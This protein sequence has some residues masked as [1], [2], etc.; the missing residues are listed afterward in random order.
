LA[1]GS[2]AEFRE[3]TPQEWARREELAGTEGR[4]YRSVGRIVAENAE[5]IDR[6]FPR[7]MR[8]V[9][10]YNLDEF[11]RRSGRNL[12]KLAVGSEGPLVAVPEA[13]INRGSTPA[14]KA[15]LVVHFA[16]L[17][18]ALE[19][20]PACLEQNPAAVELTDRTILALSRGNPELAHAASFL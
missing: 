18:E 19:A 7:I 17:I 9:G 2:E 1:D 15:L 11:A 3:L 12:S 20:P 14:A 4:I 10:G 6:R 13:T 8:R 5:E 16:D